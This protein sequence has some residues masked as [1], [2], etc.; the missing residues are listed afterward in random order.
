LLRHLLLRLLFRCQTRYIASLAT[1]ERAVP[2]GDA[3]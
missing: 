1:N 2:K 3:M